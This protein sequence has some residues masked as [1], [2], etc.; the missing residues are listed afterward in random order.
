[1]RRAR[2]LADRALEA[3]EPVYGITTG[4]GVRKRATV[5]LGEQVAFNARLILNHLVGQGAAAPVDAVRATMLVLLNGFAR[6]ASAAGPELAQRVAAALNERRHPEVRMLGSLGEA[7][8]A[9]MGDLAHG[10]VGPD[11]HLEPGEGLALLNNNA[12]STGLAALAVA[13]FERLLETALVAGALD[14]EAFGA[15]LS[16]VDPAAARERPYPGLAATIADLRRLLDGSALFAAGAGRN[17]QDPLTFRC[18]PQVHGAARDALGYAR[19]QL[20]SARHS[21]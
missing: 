7:D 3:G 1:M 13:D 15:N 19:A 4:V 2:A 10:L 5:A 21:R 18:L 16:I 8:L 17:L 12:F 9:P 20:V 11:A 14:L 6:G